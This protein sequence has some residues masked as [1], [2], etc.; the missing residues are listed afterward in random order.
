MIR[1]D[2]GRGDAAPPDATP[3]IECLKGVLPDQSLW[4]EVTE[5]QLADASFV[6]ELVLIGQDVWH[7]ENRVMTKV[8]KK[9]PNLTAFQAAL[10]CTFSQVNKDAPRLKASSSEELKAAITSAADK[11]STDIRDLLRFKD[12]QE[13]ESLD[14][15]SLRLMTQVNAAEGTARGAPDSDEHPEDLCQDILDSVAELHPDAPFDEAI[16]RERRV[17]DVS[18][19]QMISIAR[20]CPSIS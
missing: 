11:L 15:K 8:S 1:I 13:K 6:L 10:K 19:V 18:E 14:A 4:R 20:V 9:H 3:K 16:Y 5:E 7:V 12:F 2:A 17:S